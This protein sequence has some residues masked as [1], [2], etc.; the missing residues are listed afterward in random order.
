[1]NGKGNNFSEEP[2]E[3]GSGLISSDISWVRIW[4]NTDPE[5]NVKNLTPP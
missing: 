2:G 3:A 1:M 4:G 5:K